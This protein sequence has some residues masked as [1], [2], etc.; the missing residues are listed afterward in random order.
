MREQDPEL[1][2]RR[3]PPRREEPVASAAPAPTLT[4]EFGPVA[5]GQLAASAYKLVARPPA[6]EPPVAEPAQGA[7]RDIN[8]SEAPLR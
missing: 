1:D 8:G 3:G 5:A 2:L 4:R 7:A 6:A